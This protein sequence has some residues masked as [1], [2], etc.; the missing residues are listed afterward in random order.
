MAVGFDFRML[1]PSAMMLDDK[2]LLTFNHVVFKEFNNELESNKRHNLGSTLPKIFKRLQE[3]TRQKTP[4]ETQKQRKPERTG[5]K[6]EEKER[7][8]KTWIR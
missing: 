8:Q 1:P 5:F 2:K 3:Q 7:G 4:L 6:T